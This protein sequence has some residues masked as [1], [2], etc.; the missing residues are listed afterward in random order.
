[1][2]TQNN[3]SAEQQNAPTSGIDSFRQQTPIPAK[4]FVWIVPIVFMTIMSLSVSNDLFRIDDRQE[5]F[6]VG[7]SDSFAGLFSTDAFVFLRPIKNLLFRLFLAIAPFGI[8]WCH[9]AAIGISALSFFP[10]LSLFQCIFIS[11]ER[12]LIAATIWMLSPTLVSSVAWLSAVNI[13]LMVAFAAAAVSLHDSAWNGMV[14]RSRR[15]VFSSICIWLSLLSYECGVA[16]VPLLVLFDCY[17]RPERFRTKKALFVYSIYFVILFLFVILRFLFAAKLSA[18]GFIDETT[19]LQTIISSPY[20][21]VQHF[22]LWV[23]P[24]ARLC[25][26]GSYRWGMASFWT[27]AFCWLLLIAILFACLFNI[28]KQAVLKFC[29]IFFIVGF[30]PTSNCLG[31][32]NG[33]YE[34]Y[35]LGLCSIGLSGAIVAICSELLRVNGV[36]KRI[37]FTMSFL[38][39]GSRVVA[40]VETVRWARTWRSEPQIWEKSVYNRPEFFPNKLMLALALIDEGRFSE[41]VKISLDV[42]EMIAEDSLHMGAVYLIQAICELREGKNA[43]KVFELLDK[44][45]EANPSKRSEG[46]WRYYRGRVYEDLLADEALAENEYTLAM[47]SENSN[48]ASMY[49]LARIKAKKGNTDEALVL[50][51]RILKSFPNDED[52]LWSIIMLYRQI[53]KTEQADVLENRLHQVND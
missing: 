16:V 22:L 20:F 1:M 40:G 10:V 29:F 41:A 28:R 17:L 5:F 12:A 39:F 49:R 53:G 13:I 2:N 31:F 46:S 50:W 26:F 47:S 24:F 27:L 23:W 30:A 14:F 52:A 43:S 51:N 8:R 4:L 42:K 6:L 36:W 37:A 15:I 3:F 7:E 19:K 11:K 38:L 21:F 48:L 33:P 44:C 32:G 25:V 45:Y 18:E 35:Y 34:D 9:I